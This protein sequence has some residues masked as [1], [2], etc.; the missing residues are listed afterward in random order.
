MQML[1][2][3]RW[4]LVVW[5]G[6]AGCATAPKGRKDLL[7]FLADGVTRRDEVLARLGPTSARF[8]VSSRVI[9]LP[10]FR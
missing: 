10:A 8:E 5:A 1:D 9:A 6:L 3:R 7:D 2:R 4:V